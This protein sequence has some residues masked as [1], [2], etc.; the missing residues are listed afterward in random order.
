MHVH[1]CVML[2]F[3][4]WQHFNILTSA[5]VRGIS[6]QIG[7]SSIYQDTQAKGVSRK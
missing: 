1:E 3:K 7:C 4:I 2:I 6:K 5:T